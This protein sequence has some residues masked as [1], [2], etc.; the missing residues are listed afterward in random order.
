MTPNLINAQD[1][2]HVHYI[3]AEGMKGYLHPSFSA[4]SSMVWMNAIWKQ[5]LVFIVI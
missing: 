2:D 1:L 4:Q 3:E 5:C